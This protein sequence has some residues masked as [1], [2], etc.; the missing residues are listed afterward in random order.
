M[1]FLAAATLV[2]LRVCPS[3]FSPGSRTVGEK[4]PHHYLYT[5]SSSAG[6]TGAGFTSKHAACGSPYLVPWRLSFPDERGQQYLRQ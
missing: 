1:I 6:A 2:K 5:H 4:L 3:E